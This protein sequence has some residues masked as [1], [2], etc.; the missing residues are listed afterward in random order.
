MSA[1]DTL[2]SR[3]GERQLASTVALG[4]DEARIRFPLARNTVDTFEE[5]DD[6]I[7]DYYNYHYT[8]CVT[9]GGQL[10]RADAAGDAK[11]IL[12]QA[13]RREQGDIVTAYNDAHD[14]TNG[15]L[16]VV[17]DKLADG[18]KAQ[19][20]ENY[21]RDVFDRLVTPNAWERK[22]QIVREF[23]QRCDALLGPSIRADQ[24]ER[25]AQNYQDLIRSYVE[26]LQRTSSIFRR[27]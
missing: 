14:G 21:I 2:L 15:G 26:G 22:V 8:R 19:A 27:L 23:I 5:F 4:H 18:I 7:A 6:I 9:G 24:P 10:P 13:Y 25:Y 3:L 12:E 11:A 16:R 1:I 20:V 17:L